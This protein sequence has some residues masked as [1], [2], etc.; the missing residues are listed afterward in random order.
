M[1]LTVNPEDP[2]IREIRP[3]GQQECYLVLSEEERNKGFV[4]PFRDSYEHVGIRPQ[5]P[6][7]DLTPEENGRYSQF[8]YYKYEKYPEE[9][10]VVGKFWT[11]DELNSGCGAVT[12]MGRELSETYARNPKFYGATFCVGCGK[13]F[14]VAEFV[15]DGTD[16]KVGS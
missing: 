4:R 16:E 14:P 11:K 8:N 1:S 10:T 7:R 2:C 15:W 13:H 5:Y 6:L 3:D 12:K 9:E